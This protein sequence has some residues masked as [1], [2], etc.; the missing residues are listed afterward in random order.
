MS[1]LAISQFTSIFCSA[2][3][4]GAAIFVTFVEHPARMFHGTNLASTVFPTSYKRAAL[5]QAPL[6]MLGFVSSLVAWLAGSNIWWLIAG[7][8]LFS[9]MPF[10]LAMIMPTNKKLLDPKIDRDSD[11]T[12]VLL[13]TWGKLHA[14]RSV[15]STVSLVIFILN[16]IVSK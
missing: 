16:G 7:L 4:T 15:L 8:V 1:I 13:Q 3:F 6:T 9:S 2:I 14:V 5:L 11:S 10:T 12:K